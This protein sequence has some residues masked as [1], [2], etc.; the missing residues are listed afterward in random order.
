MAVI[1]AHRNN[2]DLGAR[3]QLFHS[4]GREDQSFGNPKT[5]S[6]GF[7][8]PPQSQSQAP[9]ATIHVPMR[10]PL[11]ESKFIVPHGGVDREA[12][13]KRKASKSK[14]S[15][16]RRSA[17]TPHL[18]KAQLP[19]SGVI[20]PTNDKK[21]NKLGYHRSSIACSESQASVRSS[22]CILIVSQ[23]I[24]DEERYAASSHYLKM[25]KAG[26]PIVFVSRKSATFILW[27]RPRQWKPKQRIRHGGTQQC[28]GRHLFPHSLHHIFRERH[29]QVLLLKKLRT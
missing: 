25:H 18:G 28:L 10:S 17:S 4:H 8:A 24:A 15:D 1:T 16:L 14:P 26:V 13:R 27:T 22:E 20:S 29:N 7:P 2:P 5:M 6:S 12:L 11:V 21:R 9:G 23:V 19:D 3:S